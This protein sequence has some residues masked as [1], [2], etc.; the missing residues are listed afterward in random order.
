MSRNEIQNSDIEDVLKSIRSLVNEGSNTSSEKLNLNDDAFS[1][2]RNRLRFRRLFILFLMS[3][4]VTLMAALFVDTFLSE[5]RNDASKAQEEA[6]LLIADVAEDF[7]AVLFAADRV[8]DCK[9]NAGNGGCG[10]D[11][12][13]FLEEQVNALGRSQLYVSVQASRL[14]PNSQFSDGHSFMVSNLIDHARQARAMKPDQCAPFKAE[15]DRLTEEIRKFL[16]LSG[17]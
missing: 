17:E 9:C 12:Y 8:F 4:G 14:F 13:S 11:E 15:H 1:R 10:N 16:L 6:N 2:E 3:F 7:G 5:I